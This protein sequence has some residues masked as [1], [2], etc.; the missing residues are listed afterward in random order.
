LVLQNNG[1][2]NLAVSTSGISLFTTKLTQGQ[3]Y[4]VTILSQPP[5]HTC[6]VPS[7]TGTVMSANVSVTV[8]CPWH[9]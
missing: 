1:A 8:V 3:P 7:G 9:V 6:T 2:D 4:N 5:G